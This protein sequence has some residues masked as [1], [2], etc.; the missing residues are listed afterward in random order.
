MK[1]LLLTIFALGLA[2][3]INAQAPSYL[4]SKSGNYTINKTKTDN[5]GNIIS[6]GLFN[7]VVDFDP[8]STSSFTLNSSSG[9]LF[10][11]KL[12]PNG[13]FIS[14]ANF[15]STFSQPTENNVTDVCFTSSNNYVLTGNFIGD[16]D[17]DPSPVASNTLACGV[18]NTNVFVLNLYDDLEHQS[19]FAIGG[20]GVSN[21]DYSN[22]IAC[23][24][25]DDIVITGRTTNFSPGFIDFDPSSNTAVVASFG[26]IF[27]A[28]YSN[29]GIYKWAQIYSGSGTL[30]KT[31]KAVF[32]NSTNND[33][34]VIGDCSGNPDF[35]FSA[36]TFTVPSSNFVSVFYLKLSST[37]T[38]IDAR[39]ISGNSNVEL[40]NASATANFSDIATVINS[41]GNTVDADPSATNTSTINVP[42]LPSGG[43]FV[44]KLN[45]TLNLNWAKTIPGSGNA[46]CLATSGSIYIF[47]KDIVRRY[48][49]NGITLWDYDLSTQNGIFGKSILNTASNTILLS[50]ILEYDLINYN[51]MALSPIATEQGTSVAKT[52]Y[53]KWQEN[54]NNGFYMGAVVEP[55]VCANELVTIQQPITTGTGTL[56]LHG[57][58]GWT[59]PSNMNFGVPFSLAGITTYSNSNAYANFYAE[60]TDG[61]NTIRKYFFVVIKTTA[62]MGTVAT[63]T[64]GSNNTTLVLPYSYQGEFSWISCPNF[65][66]ATNQPNVNSNNVFTPLQ[67]GSYAAVHIAQ[68][69]G[70]KDTSACVL[71]NL[72]TS[73]VENE[74]FSELII[75]PNP[76]QDMLHIEI[77][78]LKA[79]S[80]IAITDVLGKIVLTKTFIN[81]SQNIDI[82][83]LQ[84]GV[85]FVKVEN[86]IGSVSKK[87]IKQ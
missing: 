85:Y 15:G 55:T 41:A 39:T 36:N 83:S 38:F 53:T 32:C 30:S 46:S 77:A 47:S 86:R 58:G 76:A 64:I 37:G 25:N 49:H 51:P 65:T 2:T 70:C 18:N 10:I 28:K 62:G 79:N 34:L 23:D 17:F 11:T 13:T 78:N 9:A 57:P 73:I 42:N 29:S 82:S 63:P 67:N 61:V 21:H 54:G 68:Q 4:W 14:A 27:V 59:A 72:A 31:G 43:L 48:L 52:F 33:I 81:N 22:S 60:Y 44:Q 75:Y 5:L 24:T 80:T 35:D 84:S 16:A 20:S 69:T 1:K 12:D 66:L 26:G 3:L 40:S 7:G 6:I 50:G 87:F 74:K 71:F 8:S 56:S 45:S 19:S